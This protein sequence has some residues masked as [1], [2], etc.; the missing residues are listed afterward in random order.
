[1]VRKMYPRLSSSPSPS[2]EQDHPSKCDAG[3][4]PC[5]KS[6][7]PPAEH[8]AGIRARRSQA[9][10]NHR[11]PV[12][13][14]ARHGQLGSRTLRSAEARALPAI[15]GRAS[16]DLWPSVATIITKASVRLCGLQTLRSRTQ[17][18]EIERFEWTRI[19]S[20]APGGRRAR[21]TVS[22]C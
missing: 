13:G 4:T 8:A 16:A 18:R 17:R 10:L 3:R 7:Q 15:H 21:P 14:T 12:A 9:E 6:T 1:M 11:R 22:A 19:G 2:T 5:A 20:R